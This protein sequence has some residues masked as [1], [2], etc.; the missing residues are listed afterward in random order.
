MWTKTLRKLKFTNYHALL[1]ITRNGQTYWP[2][3]VVG[4]A[5]KAHSPV[6]CKRPPL[7]F[8]LLIQLL[9]AYALDALMFYSGFPILLCSPTA[10]A[11]PAFMLIPSYCITKSELGTLVKINAISVLKSR[12]RAEQLLPN[13]AVCCHCGGKHT[14]TDRKTHYCMSHAQY[15]LSVGVVVAVATGL[16][17]GCRPLAHGC[18]KA[19]RPLVAALKKCISNQCRLGLETFVVESK[20]E[21]LFNDNRWI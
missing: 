4:G 2:Q 10:G 9:N 19:W 3:R 5:Q 1:L 13:N 12:T 20:K 14:Q 18:S 6:M 16:E 15:P 7:M 17:R 8:F 11:W 21:G